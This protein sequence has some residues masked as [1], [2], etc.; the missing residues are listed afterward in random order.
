MAKIV[1]FIGIVA[2]VM[3]GKEFKTGGDFM[4]DAGTPGFIITDVMTLDIKNKIIFLRR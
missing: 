3:R 4:L 1:V 2:G